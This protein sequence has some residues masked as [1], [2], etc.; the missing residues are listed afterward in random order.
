MGLLCGAWVHAETTPTAQIT[1]ELG[2]GF[3]VQTSPLIRLSPQDNLISIDGLQQ[4][5]NSNL[6]ASVMAYDNWQLTEGLGLSLSGDLRQKR[7]MEK[8][9][10]DFGSMSVQAALHWPMRWGTVGWG[11]SYQNLEVG[12]R[13]F[14]Q[15]HGMQVDWTKADADGNHWAVILDAGTNRH[16]SDFSD[17]DADTH[18]LIVQRNIA[19]PLP[20]IDSLNISAYY[21]LEKNANGFEDLS[22]RSAMLVSSVQWS[23]LGLKWSAGGSLQ[24]VRF[25]ESAFEDEPVRADR[26]IGVDLA[27]EHELSPKHTLRLEYNEVR[28]LST[29]PLYDNQYQQFAVKILSN[30]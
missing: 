26:A 5:H 13:S 29:T 16:P 8:T 7:T 30:W 2:V 15:V 24:S 6:Q 12:R 14:R 4:L 11:L 25:A 10:S 23:W 22:S 9:E 20:G 1:T 28:S 17:L 18:A 21:T 27:V 19:A 3:E